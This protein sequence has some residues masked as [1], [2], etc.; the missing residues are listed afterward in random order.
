MI[1]RFELVWEEPGLVALLLVDGL[2]QLAEVFLIRKLHLSTVVI[3]DL[4]RLS[5][6]D[7][8]EDGMLFVPSLLKVD[9]RV[10]S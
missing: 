6:C 5:R 10:F 8:D 3:H 1:D 9:G 4:R 7:P 2:V